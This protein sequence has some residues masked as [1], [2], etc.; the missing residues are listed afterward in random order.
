MERRV[1][2]IRVVNALEIGFVFFDKCK[3]LVIFFLT[4]C[5]T[6]GIGSSTIHTALR[7]NICCS[8]NYSI[9]INT[10]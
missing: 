5:I 8:R 7:V 9:K 10:I 3:K 4:R 6:K 2:K 1:G